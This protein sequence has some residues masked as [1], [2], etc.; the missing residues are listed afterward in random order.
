MNVRLTPQQEAMVER[1]VAGGQYLT[2]SEVVREGLRLLEQELWKRDARQKIAEGLEDLKA[3]RTVDGETAVAEI[4]EN[5]RKRASPK[6][7]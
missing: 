7:S 2:A 6:K 4:L 5:L 1:L 3:G